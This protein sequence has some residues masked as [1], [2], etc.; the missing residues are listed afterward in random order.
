VDFEG[1]VIRVRASYVDGALTTPKSG[2]VHSVPMAPNVAENLVVTYL[3]N[4]VAG[5]ADVISTG[6]KDSP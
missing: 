4:G 3:P 2:K 5:N 6:S 1:Q